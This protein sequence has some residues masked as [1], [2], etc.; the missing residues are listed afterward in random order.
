MKSKRFKSKI[1]VCCCLLQLRNDEKA[2]CETGEKTISCKGGSSEAMIKCL[3]LK[4]KILVDAKKANSKFLPW[5]KQSKITQ[6]QARL[7]ALL[8][9]PKNRWR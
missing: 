7:T 1:P 3:H 5:Q 9:Q 2:K 4:H 8:K 6:V